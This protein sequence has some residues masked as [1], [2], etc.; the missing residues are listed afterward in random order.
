MRGNEIKTIWKRDEKER[1]ERKLDEK[2][3][4]ERCEK[5]K[6]YVVKV[7][8]MMKRW[9]QKS[10]PQNRIKHRNEIRNKQ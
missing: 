6:L 5:E 8:K 1:D 7:E 9:D 4:R 10:K 3:M 2:N